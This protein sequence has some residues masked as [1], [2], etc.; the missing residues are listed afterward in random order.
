MNRFVRAFL[1]GAGSVLEISPDRAGQR[2]VLRRG[3][4]GFLGVRLP[5]DGGQRTWESR[6]QA[7]NDAT[8]RRGLEPV[9]WYVTC[10]DQPRALIISPETARIEVPGWVTH[11]AAIVIGRWPARQQEQ[12]RLFVTTAVL[13]GVRPPFESAP[14]ELPAED[15]WMIGHI[16]YE[17]QGPEFP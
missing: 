1:R 4:G 17:H 3:I 14:G 2:P 6:Q 15:A 9:T 10:R 11:W 13:A 7:W 8:R 12:A 16:L 5:R